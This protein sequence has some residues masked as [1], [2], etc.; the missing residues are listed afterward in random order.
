MENQ[1]Q[2]L[3]GL[4]IK[5]LRDAEGISQEPFAH[6][7]GLDRSYLASIEVGKRNVTLTSLGKIAEGFGLTL[8]EFF[9]GI[10]RQPH[11]Q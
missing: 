8:S 10:P 11:K 5:E 6:R 1:L 7:A 3:V 2:K 9:E 4:R